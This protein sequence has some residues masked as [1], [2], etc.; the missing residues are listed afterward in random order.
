[1]K[2]K[3]NSIYIGLLLFF[4][5]PMSIGTALLVKRLSLLQASPHIIPSHIPAE[6]VF[7]PAGDCILGT[8]DPDA[9]EDVRPSRHADVPS[10]LIDRTEVTNLQFKKFRPSHIFS[11]GED[12]LPVTNVTF[13]EAEAYA[14]WAGKRL[15]T[16]EE[17]EKAARGADGRRYPWGNTWDPDK[18]AARAHPGS[19]PAAVALKLKPGQCA[20]GTSRVQPVGSLPSEKSPYGCLDMAGNAW[21]WV[22][23]F[24]N[25]NSEQR[26]LR[27][28]AVGYGERACRAY[29]R[30]IEGSG[31]T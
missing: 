23:G 5:L 6:M 20:V 21:E 3:R 7:V 22:Q 24:Y 14:K 26:I 13:D 11:H 19:H 2:R 9:D 27:G 1:L 4:L 12:N 17:W 10:F 29:S 8:D 16:E 28:G 30:A 15:P 25:G 18:V 31:V